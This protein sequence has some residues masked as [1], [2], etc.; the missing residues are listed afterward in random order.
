MGSTSDRNEARELFF[1]EDDHAKY[2]TDW[3]FVG[4]AILIEA[5]FSAHATPSATYR[6]EATARSNHGDSR[7]CCEPR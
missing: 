7:K 5:Y 3:F 1:H 6:S 2:R 4:H